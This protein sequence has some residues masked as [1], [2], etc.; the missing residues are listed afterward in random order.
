MIVNKLIPVLII[1]LLILIVLD[2]TTNIV[3]DYHSYIVAFDYFVVTTF[4]IDLIFK[5]QHLKNKKKFIKLY[6]LDLLAVFPIYLLFRAYATIAELLL[7]RQ[8]IQAQ[9]ITHTIVT[10]EREARILEE[11]AKL[12]KETK[13]ARFN[14]LG[15][16]LRFTQRVLRLIAMRFKLTHEHLK[17]ASKKKENK[18]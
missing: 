18:K 11:E 1:L 14:V 16:I 5:Y 13:L 4:V 3:E 17:L 15:R 6:W 8:L 12:A 9:Q 10:I 2:F 7:E